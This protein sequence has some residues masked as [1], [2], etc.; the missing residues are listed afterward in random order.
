MSMAAMMTVVH[1]NVH[2]G[3]GRD[4][5]PGQRTKDVGG[6]LGDQEKTTHP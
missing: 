1:E 6:V 3:T 5:Q 4:Q 2:Q